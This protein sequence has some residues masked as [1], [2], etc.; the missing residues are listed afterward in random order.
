MSSITS[1]MAFQGPGEIPAVRERC[2]HAGRGRQRGG[3]FQQSSGRLC[4]NLN[5]LARQGADRSAGRPRARGRAGRTDPGAASQEQPSLVG[6]AGVGKTAIAEETA[7]RIVDNQVPDLLSD[8]VVFAGSWCRPV[9]ST[10]ATSRTFQ[11]AARRAAQAAPPSCSST[12]SIPSSGLARRPA[13]SWTRQPAE[14][15]VVVRRDPLHRLHHV[16]GVPRHLSR[17]T[18]HWRGVSRRST[19]PS[20]RWRTPSASCALKGRFEQHHNIEYS[21]EALRAAAGW[22]RA[23]S[24]IAICRTRPST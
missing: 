2:R 13:A 11:G 15:A 19:S 3:C 5:R 16:S 22:P 12:R 21:D 18:A 1:L 6:E 8:S 20:L 23:T 17:K 7:K 9:P 10:A 14:A 24:M 4:S